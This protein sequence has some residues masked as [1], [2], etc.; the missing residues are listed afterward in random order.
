MKENTSSFKE[1]ADQLGVTEA[2]VI[3]KAIENGIIDSEGNPTEYAIKEG[4]LFAEHVDIGFSA[5]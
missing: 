2:E 5:N 3:Q 4:I 1:I